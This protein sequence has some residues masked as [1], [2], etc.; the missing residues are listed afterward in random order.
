MKIRVFL[1]FLLFVDVRAFCQ[2]IKAFYKNGS[3]FNPSVAV[4]R[5]DTC[6][7]SLSNGASA[8]WSFSLNTETG[9]DDCVKVKNSDFFMINADMYGIDWKSAK[10]YVQD[11]DSSTYYRGVVSCRTETFSYEQEVF[12][13]LL[14]SKPEILEREFI[15]DLF[16]YEY[17]IFENAKL[18][19]LV[20]CSRSESF[21]GTY[22]D[23]WL[24]GTNSDNLLFLYTFRFDENNENAMVKNMEDDD[25]FLSTGCEWGEYIYFFAENK[26]GKSQPSDT[27]FTTD[28]IKDKSVIDAINGTSGQN[29]VYAS[30][31]ILIKEGVLYFSKEVDT[32][33]IYNIM[34]TEIFREENCSKMPLYFLPKGIYIVSV[35]FSKNKKIIKKIIL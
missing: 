20:N 2:D 3:P 4:L 18:N 13:N 17:L 8:D 21:C 31:S 9:R 29:A 22:T 7:F 24:N 34:G 6:L 30:P 32:I 11:G 25:Y 14:P 26:Y 16:D 28:L 19:V 35:V 27:L 33:Y 15:Y 23:F 1:L 5:E 10:R 12:F